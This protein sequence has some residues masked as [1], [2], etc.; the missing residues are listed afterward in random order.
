MWYNKGV[1]DVIGV[2]PHLVVNR[3]WRSYRYK[4]AQGLVISKDL[5]LTKD[6]ITHHSAWP[7]GRQDVATAFRESAQIDTFSTLGSGNAKYIKFIFRTDPFMV[8][9]DWSPG[10]IFDLIGSWGAFWSSLVLI[11][12]TMA[13]WYNDKKW[14][15]L[16]EE[17]SLDFENDDLDPIF[18]VVQKRLGQNS[19]TVEEGAESSNP[20]QKSLEALRNQLTRTKSKYEFGASPDAKGAVVIDMITTPPESPEPKE[21]RSVT[22]DSGTPTETPQTKE[23][24]SVTIDETAIRDKKHKKEKR[25]RKHK[26]KKSKDEHHD[27]RLSAA[28]Q[29]LER[30]VMD[31]MEIKSN[32]SYT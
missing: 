20:L 22:M 4:F 7:L 27:N 23:K 14:H 6:I 16:A 1:N 2:D 5:Y 25:H 13:L 9:E 26:E 19:S 18:Q 30:E 11:F 32:S 10:L 3:T 24:R 17:Q 29:E 12:G 21:K 28:E 15:F 31:W 8:Q